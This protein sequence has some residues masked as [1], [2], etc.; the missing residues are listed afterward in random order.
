MLEKQNNRNQIEQK[1]REEVEQREKEADNKFQIGLGLMTFLA[2][3][4]A[5]TDSYGLA[6]GL[7]QWDISGVWI[8]LFAGLIV[9]CVVV[10]FKSLKIFRWS[11]RNLNK[12]GK[13]KIDQPEKSKRLE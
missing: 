3:I 4:S 5:V 11:V 9:F 2:A 10:F 7:S 6:S 13:E 12:S 1:E 8:V